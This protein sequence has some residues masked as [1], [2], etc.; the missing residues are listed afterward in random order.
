MFGKK[1]SL[2]E[3]V[4]GL[5]EDL[6]DKIAPHVENA[7][8]QLEP[9]LAEARE[10]AGPA[11]SDARDKAAPY[12]ADAR[13]TAAPYV[14]E[15][16]ERF[17]KAGWDAAWARA[18]R[19]GLVRIAL[20]SR[21]TATALAHLDEAHASDA[22]SAEALHLGILALRRAG[23]TEEADAALASGL[24]ADGLDLGGRRE[25]ALAKGCLEGPDMLG[26]VPGRIEIGAAEQRARLDD[27]ARGDEI[28]QRCRDD[29]LA[30]AGNG[31]RQ[32]VERQAVF[33]RMIAV[34]RGQSGQVP[35]AV[36]A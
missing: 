26:L 3:Q 21:D 24:A 20:R 35:H 1:K 36:V 30:R 17:A 29:R 25:S 32:A 27:V 13:D 18:A 15:A 12:I 9:L 28:A 10:K 7:R 2:L 31:P 19:L 23:R 8:D 14:D 4:E 33:D 22:P 11:L 5:A 34:M 16:R 6:A